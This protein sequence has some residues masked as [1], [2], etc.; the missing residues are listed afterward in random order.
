MATAQIERSLELAVLLSLPITSN[1]TNTFPIL[2]R[3]APTLAKNDLF[4]EQVYHW[5]N[6]QGSERP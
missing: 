1:L 3:R 6:G 4:Y 2:I 5:P